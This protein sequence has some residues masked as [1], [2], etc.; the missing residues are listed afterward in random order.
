MSDT[1]LIAIKLGGSVFSDK[2]RA[3]SLN[4]EVLELLTEQIAE[5]CVKGVRLIIGHGAG[6]F[7]HTVAHE[8]QTH[9]GM[10]NAQSKKGFVEV[11]YTMVKLNMLI[12]EYLRNKGLP[13]I[14][15]NP[16]SIMTTNNFQLE[17]LS[18]TTLEHSIGH[19]MI[20][21]VY[22]AQLFDT[23]KG[24]SIFSTENVLAALGLALKKKAICISKI[25]FVGQTDGVY[26]SN[27][28]TI[29][30]IT[31]DTIAQ[32]RSALKGSDGVDVTGGMLHKVE[33]ALS[34]AD[35]GIASQII[36]GT[37]RGELL[38]ALLEKEVC[39]T[40]IGAA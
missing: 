10:I 40:H 1:S 4:T 32:F 11:S 21:V 14:S 37:R 18:T 13:V 24:C 8:Y 5:A 39:G 33:K 19:G 38:R 36:N 15:L 31:K 12:L 3:F 16:Q 17:Y 28:A 9:K 27:G 29:P 6:S 7:G 25:I 22:G 34:L 26:D 20:P 23:A 2:K 30:E 35:Q